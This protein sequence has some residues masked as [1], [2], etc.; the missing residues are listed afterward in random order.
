MKRIYIL[1]ISAVS[2]FAGCEEFQPVFTGTYPDPQVQDIYTDEYFGGNFTP[3][4]EVK[5]MYVDNDKKPYDIRKRCVIKGQ[6]ITSDKTGN[7]YKSFYIQDETAG[8]EIKI[9]KNGLYNDYKVGQWIY[10]DCTDLTVGSY[11]GMVQIGYKDE[12][13]EY[14]TAYLEHSVI[15][16]NHVY[17][18]AMATEE[19][20]IKPAVISGSQVYDE[21]YL[22]TLVTIEGC[23]YSNLVFLI[24]YIDP[25]IVN[26]AD[27]KS[28][29]NRFFLDD[30]DGTNWGINSWAM[31]ESLFKEHVDNGDF[32]GAVMNDGVTVGERKHLIK[33]QPYTMNQFFEMPGLSGNQKY[34]QVRS[35]GY[36]KWSDVNI[37]SPV[38]AG[39]ETVTFTGVLTTF[40]G[41]MQFTL[42]DLSGVTKA[43]GSPW[44]DENN[45]EIL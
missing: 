38:L 40:N 23:K 34:L 32:D 19:E 8:I 11:E 22:G 20:L 17:K 39:D 3:I 41:E 31:S 15:V 44:Y 9:G 33:P 28:N 16:D 35:S 7:I 42:I 12:T 26:E 5:Q 2:L 45:K 21:K 36:A 18:G 10:V 1:L 14:E 6:I 43:D 24:G 13:G 29:Q 30:E 25:N 37:P 27:K 4:S